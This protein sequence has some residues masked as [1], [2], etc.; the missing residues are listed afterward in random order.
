[1]NEEQKQPLI[2][3]SLFEQRKEDLQ[4]VLVLE[5]KAK[6]ARE[7]VKDATTDQTLAKELRVRH[8]EEYELVG[9]TAHFVWKDAVTNVIGENSD[10]D[11]QASA[12]QVPKYKWTDANGETHYTSGK[13]RSSWISD[14]A[15][16]L[17]KD[18]K[19]DFSKLAL[20]T[21]DDHSDWQKWLLRS[22]KRKLEKQSASK[23]N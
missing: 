11:S 14:N 9:L 7:R 4:E 23:K 21:H 13:G 3:K 1:M 15:A 12:K 19:T 5:R 18:D 17:I 22:K 16:E 2:K 8:A 20:T 6:E 10:N